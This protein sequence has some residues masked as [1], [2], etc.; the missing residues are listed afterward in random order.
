MDKMNGRAPFGISPTAVDAAWEKMMPQDAE[1][2]RQ[3]FASLTDGGKWGV[4]RSELWF[5]RQGDKLVLTNEK[6][7]TSYRAADFATIRFVFAKAGID[8]EVAA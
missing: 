6:E 2:C 5:Q 1:W 3:L 4:P 7:L 8:V